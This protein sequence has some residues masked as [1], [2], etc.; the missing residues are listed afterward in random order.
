[1]NFRGVQNLLILKSITYLD[2]SPGEEAAWMRIWLPVDTPT[3][4]LWQ[5]RMVF[6]SDCE[7]LTLIGKCDGFF[8]ALM[9]KI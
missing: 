1:M 3:N 9:A 2:L 6:P 7:P 5:L 4:E 8:H